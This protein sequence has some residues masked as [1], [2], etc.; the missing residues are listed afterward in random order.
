MPL[1]D[2]IKAL[3]KARAKARANRRVNM[4]ASLDAHLIRE[5]RTPSEHE[6]DRITTWIYWT[7]RHAANKRSLK[8]GAKIES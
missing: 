5:H 2:L 4:Q 8:L 6:E 1:L 3:T 7:E